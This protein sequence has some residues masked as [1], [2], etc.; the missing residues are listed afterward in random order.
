MSSDTPDRKVRYGE[1]PA[2]PPKKAHTP[3][4]LRLEHA[5]AQARWMTTLRQVH[6]RAKSEGNE[7]VAGLAAEAASLEL[8]LQLDELGRE[9]FEMQ[10]PPDTEGARWM[11]CFPNGP[12][13]PAAEG[14]VHRNCLPYP[15]GTLKA[16]EAGWRVMRE[17]PD[18]ATCAACGKSE[19]PDDYAHWLELRPSL[20]EDDRLAI[21]H[22]EMRDA[23]AWQPPLRPL[24]IETTA[25]LLYSSWRIADLRGDGMFLKGT[26]DARWLR[27]LGLPGWGTA[28]QAVGWGVYVD[29]GFTLTGP[30]VEQ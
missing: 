10:F 12:L 14:L 16:L 30:E 4:Q 25:R 19:E 17:L 22:G 23:L 13:Q 6:A 29:G 9:F 7:K 24:Q 27:L 21:L 2:R 20:M 28:L 3:S 11:V 8:E 26:N 5:D 1:G 15:A 18:G